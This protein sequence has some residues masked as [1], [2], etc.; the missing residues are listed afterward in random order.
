MPD[1][2]FRVLG[3]VLRRRCGA[4]C[5]LVL[6]I[7]SGAAAQQSDARIEQVFFR[8]AAL[9]TTASFTLVRPAADPPRDGYPVLFIL[10]GLGRNQRTL[11]DNPD[12]RRLLLAQRYVIVLPD[13][14]R[15]WW[16]D[17]GEGK[18]E[19]ML[20]EVVDQ[21]RAGQSVS[22]LRKRWA[23]LGWSMGGFGAVHF[24]EDHPERF[25]FVGSIIGLLDFPKVEGLPADQRFP[26]D[27]RV[28]G[29][30]PRLWAKWNPCRHAGSLRSTRLALVIADDAFDHTMNEN[31]L[32]CARLAGLQPKANHIPGAHVFSSVQEGLELLLP[33][34]AQFFN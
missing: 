29:D 30:N 22:H 32:R 16:M 6:L 33:Q 5:T 3:P 20:L 7:A 14:Q 21:V 19:S 31:F 17:S 13:S 12:T 25:G 27:Q 11:I 10:H 23:I 34:V 18:Y 1:P 26:V 4:C 15:G 2:M 28:F 9:Q 8:S 24:A